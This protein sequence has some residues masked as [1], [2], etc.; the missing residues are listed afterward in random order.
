M[1]SQ[2]PSSNKK[3]DLKKIHTARKQIIQCESIIRKVLAIYN[4]LDKL[5]QFEHTEDNRNYVIRILFLE[6]QLLPRNTHPAKTQS[7][8]VNLFPKEVSCNNIFQDTQINTVNENSY[9]PASSHISTPLFNRS[10]T[11]HTVPM[12]SNPKPVSQHI[13][14]PI[15]SHTPLST[16]NLVFQNS[17]E[18]ECAQY[19]PTFSR[20][21]SNVSILLLYS[22]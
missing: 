18:S 10:S 16:S 9:K 21:D 19:S 20:H 8:P 17:T 11:R 14:T 3:G 1:F 15:P 12:V 7:N 4:C 5:E 2:S 22:T 13:S 6:V